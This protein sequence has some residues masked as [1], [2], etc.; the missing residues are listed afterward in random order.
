MNRNSLLDSLSTDLSTVLSAVALAKVEALAKDEALREGGWI[1]YS[2][3]MKN[4]KDIYKLTGM[5]K[6]AG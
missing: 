6:A 2:V 5:V 1:L 4:R 3:L